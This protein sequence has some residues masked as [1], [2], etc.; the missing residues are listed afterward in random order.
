M[1]IQKF[2]DIDL[3]SR[4][5]CEFLK[6]HD[7][8]EFD[9]GL[10]GVQLSG[11]DNTGEKKCLTKTDI[12]LHT[13]IRKKY[14][15]YDTALHMYVGSGKTITRVDH[16]LKL[17][18]YALLYV[19]EGLDESKLERIKDA[20][21]NYVPESNSP[22]QE[23]NH[24]ESSLLTK[25]DIVAGDYQVI[26]S[27]KLSRIEAI[28]F[29]DAHDSEFVLQ[30]TGGEEKTNYVNL[31]TLA[32]ESC[33]V[34]DI[35]LDNTGRVH[36]VANDM[37]T[38][39]PDVLDEKAREAVSPASLSIAKKQDCQD[40]AIVEHRI[41]TLF[42]YPEWRVIWKMREIELGPCRIAKTKLPVLQT[43]TTKKVL[44]GTIVV[45]TADVTDILRNLLVSC[46]K[47]SAIV[48]GLVLLIAG[49]D[50][51]TALNAFGIS[52][53]ACIVAGVP[54]IVKRCLIP[55]LAIL[56]DRGTWK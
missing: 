28:S 20:F 12:L 56:T 4:D 54:D 41:G 24:L 51:A 9:Y 44:Y 25:G 6:D 17:S 55:D 40:L 39:C 7:Q 43:R 10:G 36:E 47:E 45:S 32:E 30:A 23:A 52:M 31:A 48:G 53:R 3:E 11:H 29:E 18:L 34:P 49:G 37:S 22:D 42:N 27:Y 5:V 15:V 38:I 19:K 26:L 1:P 50:F 16:P 13:C 2:I 46:M 14:N 35:N 21:L 8:T 33:V